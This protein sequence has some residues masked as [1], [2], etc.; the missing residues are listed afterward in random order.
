M[1]GFRPLVRERVALQA[2]AV[3]QR[4]GFVVDRG[5]DHAAVVRGCLPRYRLVPFDDDDRAVTRQALRDGQAHGPAADDHHIRVQVLRGH[6]PTLDGH[7]AAR[8]GNDRR[9]VVAALDGD[10]AHTSHALRA[11]QLREPQRDG[12]RHLAREHPGWVPPAELHAV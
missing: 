10:H 9:L 12:R 8:A 7:L 3:L 6:A 2:E 1:V 5:V 4:S 11:G